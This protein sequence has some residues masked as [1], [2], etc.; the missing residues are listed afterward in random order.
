MPSSELSELIELLAKCQELAARIAMPSP[1]TFPFDLSIAPADTPAPESGDEITVTRYGQL[2]PITVAGTETN[3]VVAPSLPNQKFTIYCVLCS[4]GSRTVTFPSAFNKDGDVSYVISET[5]DH[6]TFESVPIGSDS[7]A[8]RRI[9]LELEDRVDSIALISSVYHLGEAGM[10]RADDTD[11]YSVA[12]GQANQVIFQAALDNLKKY[13]TDPHRTIIHLPGGRHVI[14]WGTTTTISDANGADVEACLYT[15]P[16][17]WGGI[18]QGVGSGRI[19]QAGLDQQAPGGTDSQQ[20]TMSALVGVGDEPT[21]ATAM[22]VLDSSSKVTVRDM[23]FHGRSV[24]SVSRYANTIGYAMTCGNGNIGSNLH[25]CD[26]LTFDKFETCISLGILAATHTEGA[27]NDTSEFNT[28]HFEDADTAV[29]FASKNCLD[30]TFRRIVYN[31]V[32]D[33]FRIYGGGGLRFYD[34]FSGTQLARFLAFPRLGAN[35][36]IGFA[37]GQFVVNSMMAH[38]TVAQDADTIWV[39]MSDWNPAVVETKPCCQIT[40]N[41]LHDKDPDAITFNPKFDVM[42]RVTLNLI[43]CINLGDECLRMIDD[44][45]AYFPVVTME[46]C[47]LGI[48]AALDANLIHADSASGENFDFKGINNYDYFGSGGGFRRHRDFHYINGVLQSP[49]ALFV[50]DTDSSVEGRIWYDDSENKIKLR[51]NAGVETITSA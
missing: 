13:G 20:G 44:G 9:R 40:F 34:G 42:G 14:D 32:E 28:I 23:A 29:V 27:G 5:G 48:S 49:N 2:F 7:Y 46:R 6:V 16:D 25:K 30:H 24:H 26:N 50:T 21:V 43:E 35:E 3:T 41:N 12:T 36:W 8:W 45:S 39:D 17:T 18:I 33:A 51:T 15:Q 19:Q 47:M 1:A 37:Q 38:N 11:D 31:S 22:L 10:V 4:S